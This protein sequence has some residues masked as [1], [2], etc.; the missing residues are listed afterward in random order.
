[1][2][3]S[4]SPSRAILPALLI[5][6]AAA[7]LLC[8]YEFIRSSANTLFKQAY[9][10]EGLPYIMALM[11]IGVLLMLYGYGRSLSRFGPRATLLITTLLSAAAV[12]AC[13]GLIQ[14]KIKAASGVLYIVREAYVV[15]IIEQLWSFLNSRLSVQHA[16][17]LNGPICG[18]GSIG[19]IA[20]GFAVAA[21][22]KSL[23][24][25]T[26]LIFGALA[27]LPALVCALLAYRYCGEPVREADTAT[28][29]DT[30]GVRLLTRERMLLFLML[31]IIATQVISSTTDLAFQGALQD[32]YP[33]ANEQNAVSGAFYAWLN[34]FSAVGQ[35]LVAPLLLFLAPLWL[36]LLILP[37]LNVAACV[38]AWSVPSLFA[39][40]LAYQV[41]KAIDYSVFRAAKE[42]L[43]IPLSFD[44][45]FRAKELIDV[46]G[47]RF[48]KGATAAL[49]ALFAGLGWVVQSASL[50][51][52]VA[53]AAAAVWLALTPFLMRSRAKEDSTLTNSELS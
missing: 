17:V 12:F 38:Y 9:G 43:Y 41:F 34:V 2:D 48:S 36:V 42:P 18:L 31:I 5:G 32:R 23:G 47:Y 6:L 35:F 21:Y 14:A 20:G 15:L 1:M 49:I 19:A 16:R 30:L 45:R 44:A 50:F 26:M 11:P 24:T 29:S 27:M 25:A 13:Y 7:F 10:K 37:L 22:S 52:A 53:V 39:Y 46:W 28:S 3:S 8:G 4:D 33:D 40:G 51:S